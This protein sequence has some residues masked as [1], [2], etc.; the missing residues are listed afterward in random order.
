[1]L[2]PMD[3]G[4]AFL[5]KIEQTFKAQYVEASGQIHL[6]IIST[7]PALAAYFAI[8]VDCFA[9]KKNNKIQPGWLVRRPA[10]RLRQL[11]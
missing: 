4:H 6:Q 3:Y 9:V 1:M 11:P 5:P 10:H 2:G 7:A 8:I